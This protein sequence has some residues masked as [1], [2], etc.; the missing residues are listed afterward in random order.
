MTDTMTRTNTFTEY[1]HYDGRNQIDGFITPDLKN[2][3]TVNND[4]DLRKK[5]FDQLYEKFPVDAFTFNNQGLTSIAVNIFKQLYGYIPKS[6]HNRQVT[7]II[8][9]YYPKA[10]QHTFYIDKDTEQGQHDIT[11]DIAKDFPAVLLTN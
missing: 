11:L 7:T 6:D 8:D 3:V 4:Y 2:M 9:D 5:I 1:F 10:L